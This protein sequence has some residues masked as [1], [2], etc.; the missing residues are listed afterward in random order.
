MNKKP[1]IFRI[2]I[3]LACLLSFVGLLLPYESATKEYKEELQKNP[4]QINVAGTELTNKDAINIS[5]I[6]NF[7]V[8][9]AA[10]DSLKNS[11]LNDTGLGGAVIEGELIFNIVLIV[12]LIASSVLVLLF[13]I[14]NR[15]VLSII[16]SLLLLGSSLLMNG[17]I[18][19]RGVVPSSKYAIG[20]SYYLYPVMAIIMIVSTIVLIIKEKKTINQQ[21]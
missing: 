2:I 6:E 12:I 19:A 3:V 18:V 10:L 1:N 8:Y 4:E 11:E 7:K 17:D 13:A 14:F 5:I 9:F 21:L 16:F 15:R 20:I